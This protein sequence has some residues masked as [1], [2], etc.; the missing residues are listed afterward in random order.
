MIKFEELLAAAV[1]MFVFLAGC[2]HTERSVELQCVGAGSVREDV[3]GPVILKDGDYVFYDSKGK[4]R[5]ISGTC[6]VR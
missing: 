1:L 2:A 4:L 3:D 5:K 6:G